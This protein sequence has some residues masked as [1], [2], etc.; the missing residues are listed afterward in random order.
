MPRPRCINPSCGAE[1]VY[2]ARYCVHCGVLLAPAPRLRVVDF[3]APQ[4]A[5][6]PRLED[7]TL[8]PRLGP[9]GPGPR[10]APGM[11]VEFGSVAMVVAL[12]L[13]LM[14]MVNSDASRAAFRTVRT[15]ETPSALTATPGR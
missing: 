10:R 7:C 2:G 9:A 3:G 6:R 12:I 14:A 8:A 4:P 15:I 13:A 11:P 1:G 5:A